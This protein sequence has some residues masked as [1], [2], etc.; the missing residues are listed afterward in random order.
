MWFY[1]VIFYILSLWCFVIWFKVDKNNKLKY[2][3]LQ[4][5]HENWQENTINRF[6][7]LQIIE[8]SDLFSDCYIPGNCLTE[9]YGAKI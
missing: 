6:K 7:K 9:S 4:Q 8:F 2:H 1:Y 5:T 3:F